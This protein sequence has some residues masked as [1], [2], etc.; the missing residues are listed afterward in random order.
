MEVVPVQLCLVGLYVILMDILHT[1][2]YFLWMVDS[3]KPAMG[4]AQ[5]DS[6]AERRLAWCRSIGLPCLVTL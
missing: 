5:D 1:V 6:M 3:L 4:D 2:S